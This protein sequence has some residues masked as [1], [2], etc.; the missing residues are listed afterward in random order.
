M[1]QSTWKLGSGEQVYDREPSHIHVGVTPDLLAEAMSKVFAEPGEKKVKR[2]IDFDR[3]IGVSNCVRTSESDEIV[4]AQRVHRGGLTRFAKNR[5]PEPTSCLTLSM[6]LQPDGQYELGTAYIGSPGH[7]EYWAA[8]NA[9]EFQGAIEFWNQN[10][11]CWGYEP[12]LPGT[13]TTERP[14]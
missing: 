14:W 5:K 3:I 7:N 11:L 9:E 1:Q 8:E 12:V 6:R 10:A 13:E 2:T 4:F